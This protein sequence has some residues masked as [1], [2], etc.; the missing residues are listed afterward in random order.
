MKSIF[1]FSFLAVLAASFFLTGCEQDRCTRTEEYIAY[2]PVF[3]RI[4]E[5]RV[6]ASF[7]AARSLE[8]PGKIFYYKGYLLINEMNKGIHVI[9]NSNP[10][11]P[12]NIGFIDLPGTLDMAVNNDILYADNYLDLVGI[13]I[14]NP[15]APVEVNRVQDVFQSFY[16]FNDQLGYLV[17]YVPTPTKLTIDC[18]DINWGR[19]IWFNEDLVMV[20]DVSVFGAGI[21]SGSAVSSNVVTGGS[22]ARFTAVNNYLYTIDGAQIKIFDVT[23][24][25]PVLKNKLD[26]QWGV[27][28][29]FPMANNLFIGSNSGLLIYDISNPE[30]PEFRSTFSHATACDPV[31]VSGNTAYVTLRDGNACQGFVNQLDVIDVSNLN[32]PSLIKSYPMDNPHGLS[33]VDNTLYLCEGKFGLKTF[34]ISENLKIDKNLLD[35]V[36][37]FFG[38]DVIVLPPG[39][40]VM[41]IGSDGLYQFDAKIR[42]DL[43]QISK[44]SIGK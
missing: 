5:M 8:S 19:G 10:Q 20:K 14:S 32:N 29:L 26:V 4:D 28:T 35:R 39:D 25:L 44:I 41:V 40:L 24:S 42:S 30:S 38:W 18:N 11:S 36:S 22:M 23:Q 13:D 16:S 1:Q 34:D 2:E 3:K 37:G 12:V 17:E 6:P 7:G 31:A 27:E 33:I 15:T 9:D 21:N 43:K